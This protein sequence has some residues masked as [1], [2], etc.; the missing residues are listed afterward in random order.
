MNTATERFWAKVEVKGPD[1]CWPW[2]GCRLPH[3]YG[4]ISLGGRRWLT[5]RLSYELANGL[6]PAG[7]YVCHHCDSP[8]CVNPEHLF[9][10]TQG[11]NQRDCVAKGRRRRQNLTACIHGHPYTPESTITRTT[12]VGRPYRACRTCL[13]NLKQKRRKELKC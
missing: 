2:N 9:L 1:D 13:N 11:D 5:H 12:R 6:I 7:L 3:G 8:P 10:G 4:Q